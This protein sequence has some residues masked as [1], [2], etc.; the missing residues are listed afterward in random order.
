M[1]TRVRREH[2]TAQFDSGHPDLRPGVVTEACRSDTAADH[3]SSRRC[4]GSTPPRAIQISMER[5]DDD[6]PIET[7]ASERFRG[8]GVKAAQ[9][10]FNLAGEG[11]IPSGPTEAANSDRRTARSSTVR[12]GS[13]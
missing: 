2:E 6:K 11:S 4:P 8:R 5:C 7:P 9:Q 3:R 13:L 1:V 10:T 12:A